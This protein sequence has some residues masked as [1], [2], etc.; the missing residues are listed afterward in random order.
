M[1]LTIIGIRM[2]SDLGQ[3]VYAEKWGHRD[4]DLRKVGLKLGDA[5]M[6][7]HDW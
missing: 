1:L 5:W 7:E 2:T 3:S 4:C 6:V